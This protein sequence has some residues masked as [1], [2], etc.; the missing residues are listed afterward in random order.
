MSI[1]TQIA[2]SNQRKDEELNIAL[3]KKVAARNDAAAVKELVSNLTNKNKE[4]QSDCIKVLYEIG[5]L[6]K[7]LIAPYYAEFIKLLGNKNNRLVWGAMT[8]LGS[9]VDIKADLIGKRVNEVIQATEKGSVI[10]Q[11]WGIRVLA[12]ISMKNQAQSENIFAFLMNFLRDC[13]AKDVPRHAESILVAVNAG[14]REAFVRV[15][16]ERHR[17]LAPSQAKRAEK[18]L[19]S[20]RV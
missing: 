11:D 12:A 8:A 15:L 20:L 14:N 19:K 7:D 2:S 13:P 16:K 5:G 4:I 18:I 10:T 6:N 9:I 3:A 1:I 17:N